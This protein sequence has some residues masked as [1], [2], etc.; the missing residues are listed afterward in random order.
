MLLL[1][2]PKVVLAV[3]LFCAYIGSYLTQYSTLL[4]VPLGH[5]TLKL[6]SLAEVQA[7]PV[8]QK[9]RIS[10][11][12]VEYQPKTSDVE[13]FIRLYCSK[14]HFVYVFTQFAQL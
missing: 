9:H 5:E 14:C 13:E 4:S 11:K 2:L 6:S 8:P 10:A 1:W 7:G 12:L 3:N